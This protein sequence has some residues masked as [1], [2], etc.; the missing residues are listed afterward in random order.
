MCYP[1]SDGGFKCLVDKGPKI[2]VRDLTCKKRGKSFNAV[3]QTPVISLS[4]SGPRFSYTRVSD[5]FLFGSET[6]QTRIKKRS[7]IHL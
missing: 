7:D 6:L 5:T 2:H 1:M 3:F 4:W